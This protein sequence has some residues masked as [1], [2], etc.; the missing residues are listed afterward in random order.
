MPIYR[1]ENGKLES[2]PGNYSILDQNG[3]IPRESIYPR[4]GYYNH[5]GNID[6]FTDKIEVLNGTAVENAL[7]H[8][9]DLSTG[10]GT[11]TRA[12]YITKTQTALSSDTIVVSYIVQN[13]GV[14]VAGQR[15]SYIGFCTDFSVAPFGGVK[16]ICLM[17]DET[18]D[19][20]TVSDDSIGFE[21]KVF[22]AVSNGDRITII[23]NSSEILFYQNNIL[24]NR[25]SKYITTDSLSI[26]ACVF[27][28][29][30]SSATTDRTLSIDFI[31]IEQ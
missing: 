9:V 10:L 31:G 19:W 16:T 18:G 27:I 12:A 25:H 17:Q 30:A 1:R 5:N 21:S 11:N 24:I 7:L 26:G 3:Y 20:R 2:V 23:A 28:F 15:F 22:P 8:R 29:G 14:G 4:V 13:I 6:N